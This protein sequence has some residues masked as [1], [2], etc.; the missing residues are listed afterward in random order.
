MIARAL[1]SNG[2]AQ[3][4]VGKNKVTIKKMAVVAG[5]QKNGRNVAKV[6]A[7][8]AAAGAA[9]EVA[10]GVAGVQT[11]AVAVEASSSLSGKRRRNNIR[12]GVSLV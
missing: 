10:A 7:V 12:L 11:V 4:K 6:E 1:I 9:V 2:L 5:K 3:T 8:E